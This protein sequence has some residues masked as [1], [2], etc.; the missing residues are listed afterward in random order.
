MPRCAMKVVLEESSASALCMVGF[1]GWFEE[2]AAVSK[3]VTL[4]A[5]LTIEPGISPDRGEYVQ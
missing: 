1:Q 5:L 2:P 3:L 4:E